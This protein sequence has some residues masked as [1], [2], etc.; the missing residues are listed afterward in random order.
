MGSPQV[1]EAARRESTDAHPWRRCQRFRRDPKRY[2][3][4][5][6]RSSP[7][8]GRPQPRGLQDGQQAGAPAPCQAPL[9]VLTS[10]V[11]ESMGSEQVP[12]HLGSPEPAQPA[13]PGAAK[14]GSPAL[15]TPAPRPLGNQHPSSQ[16]PRLPAPQL[17]AP[18]ATTRMQRWAVARAARSYTCGGGGDTP[19]CPHP[20]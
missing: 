17:P 1:T 12:G 8:S 16:P 15:S 4:E 7:H 10:C 19:A 9:R 5:A 20:V 13:L 11:H 2:R 6:P 18:R 3:Q 14:P